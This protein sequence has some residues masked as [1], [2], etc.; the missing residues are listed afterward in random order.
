MAG[1]GVGAAGGTGRNWAGMKISDKVGGAVIPVGVGRV[2]VG[3]GGGV[4]GSVG[5]A[6]AVGVTLV[7]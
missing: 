2:K 6:A 5:V 3:A 7:P 1:G 4:I